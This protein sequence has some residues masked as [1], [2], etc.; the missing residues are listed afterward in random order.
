[1]LRVFR[2]DALARVRAVVPAFDG[3]HRWLPALFV[4][5]GLRVVQLPV[6]HGPRPAGVSKYTTR[7]RLLPIA[8]ELG[9]VLGCAARRSRAWRAAAVVVV[10]GLVALPYLFALGAWPLMEP[11]EPRNAEVAREMLTLGR[12]VTPHFNG[13]PYLDKPVLLFWM[14]AGAFRLAGVG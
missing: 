8:R 9:V 4:L 6:P 10:L 12:W 3:A 2:A 11:D 14:I 13:L 1:P 5:A 7:G